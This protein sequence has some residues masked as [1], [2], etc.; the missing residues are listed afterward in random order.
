MPTITR[1]LIIPDL[2]HHTENADYWMDSI[3]HDR[4]VF[5]GDFFDRYG[6]EAEDATRTAEWVS[7]QMEREN[8]VF[9]FGNHD[10]PYRFHGDER[11]ECPGFSPAKSDAINRVLKRKHWDRF[12]LAHSEQG[13][14]LSHAGFHP[15]WMK[16]ASQEAILARCDAAM[17]LAREGCIDPILGM[18]ELPR[19]I[20]K[21]GGPLW[22]DWCSFM[23]IEGISQIVG[24]S[25][26]D[27]VR[28]IAAEGSINHCIDVAYGG[29]AALI[30][31]GKV[32][33]LRKK[34]R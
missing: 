4:V 23:P 26:D 9:I 13:W 14:L 19:G 6:D 18:G 28:T 8:A 5:L 10:L 32:K 3:P 31:D 11:V 17:R 12:C 20:Q 33:I 25:Q 15:A 24:H 21:F 22:M 30:V 2:H 34:L 7:R 27:E 1:T 16:G 29:A